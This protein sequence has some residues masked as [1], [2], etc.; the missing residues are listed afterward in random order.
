[1]G[2]ADYFKKGDFNRICDRCGLKRKASE[3][4]KEWTGLIVCADECFETRH[5]QEFV[6]GKRDKQR[7]PMPRP[8]GANVFLE[9]TDVTADDL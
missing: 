8:E 6:R 7:V 1:M 4:R 9:P 3:T 5:P 2:R